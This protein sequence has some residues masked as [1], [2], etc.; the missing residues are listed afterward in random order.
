MSLLDTLGALSAWAYLLVFVAALAE[1]L[2]A[3]GTLVPGHSIVIAAGAAASLGSL[4]AW[5]VFAVSTV[6]AVIGDACAYWI[7]RSQGRRFLERHGPRF[8]LT[9]P[10]VA[11]SAGLL[12]RN[13][14][15]AIVGGR[16]SAVTRAIVPFVAGCLEYRFGLFSAYNVV[17][18]VLWAGSSVILG[19][20]V[21][22]SYH[23]A[24]KAFG[25]VVLVAVLALVGLY[26]AYRL[27]RLVSPLIRRRDALAFLA[28]AAGIALRW[29]TTAN[30]LEGDHLARIDPKARA[31]L[32][33]HHTA[34][35][36]R[37]MEGVSF[38]GGGVVLALLAVGGI[39]LLLW[40]GRRLD[41]LLVAIAAAGEEV[42]VR[43]AK[44]L[45]ARAGPDLPHVTAVGFS[46]PSGHAAAA[47]VLAVL[48]AWLAAGRPRWQ[49]GLT[50]ALAGAWVLL[51]GLSQ[52]VLQAHYFTDV[53]GGIGL[54]LAVAGGV[55]CAPGMWRG[56]RARLA[57]RPI[58]V[59]LEK[60]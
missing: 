10:R 37:L 2:P 5:V 25:G 58:A 32:D 41:A 60:P 1:A 49:L 24:A 4:N 16:F 27:V 8:G 55:V 30:V 11:R 39:A 35:L 12:E 59:P 38:L 50:V 56:V 45:A 6:G 14:F 47:T 19:Y 20:V 22:A 3:V 29:V 57:T 42:A 7:G 40:R 23:V 46:F 36:G 53:V 34:G 33:A 28:A 31:L 51:V 54:G 15:V 48:L 18:A 9:P 26:L 52:L 17:G 21:G 44:A 13:P 43:V